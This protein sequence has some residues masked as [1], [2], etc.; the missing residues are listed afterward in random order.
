VERPDKMNN[1]G[2]KEKEKQV[3]DHSKNRTDSLQMPINYYIKQKDPEGSKYKELKF[4]IR[5]NDKDQ[6]LPQNIRKFFQHVTFVGCFN[7]SSIFIQID[8][9]LYCMNVIPCL[10]SF[11]REY[12]QTNTL[13]IH[14]LTDR[15][16]WLDLRELIT[17]FLR[18]KKLEGKINIDQTI[19]KILINK[20]LIA[21]QY[22]IVIEETPQRLEGS[23]SAYPVF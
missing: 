10:E 18:N 1:A 9:S 14:E 20:Y 16:Q 11:I 3:Y 2:N 4:N 12:L 23:I 19:D 13:L 8:I 22:G 7:L 21:K 17:N 15:S 6:L 5:V